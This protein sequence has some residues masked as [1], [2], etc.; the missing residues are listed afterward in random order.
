[1]KTFFLLQQKIIINNQRFLVDD[2]GK[3]I[4]K[5]KSNIFQ[6]IFKVIH[7]EDELVAKITQKFRF[8]RQ[9]VI[10]M[11]DGFII[12]VKSSKLLFHRLKDNVIIEGFDHYVVHGDIDKMNFNIN[13]KGRHALTIEPFEEGKKYRRI[14]I[15]NDSIEAK[16][17]SILFTI[18]LVFDHTYANN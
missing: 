15:Q 14:T 6:T 3:T 7:N 18:L 12:K 13:V 10:H 2:T 4:Y 9:Y 5:F 11:N 17:I 16:L 1:M 8:R